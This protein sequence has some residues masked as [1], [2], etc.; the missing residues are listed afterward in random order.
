M[1]HVRVTCLALLSG[2]VAYGQSKSFQDCEI[3]LEDGILKASNSKI[4]ANWV[5]NDSGHLDLFS[6]V[7]RSDQTPWVTFDQSLLLKNAPKANPETV[8]AITFSQGK[9]FVTESE[10]LSAQI[11]LSDQT[12][13]L[14]MYPNAPGILMQWIGDEAALDQSD[15]EPITFLKTKLPEPSKT[16]LIS[17]T[18][19]TNTDHNHGPLTSEKRFTRDSPVSVK[20]NIITAE[21]ESGSALTFFKL[22]PIPIERTIPYHSDLI[23]NPVDGH[24]KW[25]GLALNKTWPESY[26]HALIVSEKG[27]A[28]RIAALQDFQRQIRNYRPGKDGI[29]LSNTWGDGNRDSRITR[30]F[31]EGEIEAGA[32]L[33][34][35]VIQVD[36]G[37][38]KGK[39]QNSA[40]LDKGKKGIWAGFWE[41]ADEFWST[42]LERFPGGIAALVAGAKEKGMRFGLWYALDSS[43]NFANWEKDVDMVVGLHKKYD[44]DYFKFDAIVLGSVESE[45]RLQKLLLGVIEKSGGKISVDLDVTAGKRPGY[46]GALRSG[47]IF[48]ENRYVSRG[49][50]YPYRTLRNFWL[51]SQYMD[52]ARLRMEFNNNTL[53]KGRYEKIMAG[54]RYRRTYG[55]AKLAPAYY[56]SDYLFAGVMFGTPLAWLETSQL[57]EDYRKRI[58]PLIKKWREHRVAIHQGNII[59]IGAQP[60]G[61]SWTGFVSVSKDRKTGYALLFRE[62]NPKGEHRFELPLVEGGFQAEV[63]HSNDDKAKV[64]VSD[65][66]IITKLSREKAYVFVKLTR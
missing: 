14:R 26:E 60:N 21:H 44:V 10:S 3:S 13:H 8:A 1:Q 57:P 61:K 18:L 59:P 33:G 51:L 5:V 58:T 34:V 66:T 43:S 2:F 29:L 52:P 64:T 38:Q 50:Y 54:G 35:D 23:F 20:S 41:N 11:Q 39:S 12:F 15:D 25:H 6:L 27:R 37:W 19:L 28:G 36:D 17:A 40:R 30:K 4:T 53:N 45:K 42:D 16:T 31:V 47:Q 48:V 62:V 49:S 7:N 22:A 63:I 56:E 32:A 65:R 24:L 46:F 9:A 55:K